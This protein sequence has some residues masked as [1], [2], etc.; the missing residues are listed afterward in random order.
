TKRRRHLL[1]G[2]W[3]RLILVSS[4]VGTWMNLLRRR[5]TT[6]TAKKMIAIPGRQMKRTMKMMAVMMRTKAAAAAPTVVKAYQHLGSVLR[7]GQ[8]TKVQ[9]LYMLGTN[10]SRSL[11]HYLQLPQ[12]TCGQSHSLRVLLAPT[13]MVPPSDVLLK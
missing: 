10:R 5:R 4:S 1:M 6:K 11:S 12:A 9:F 2:L 8:S 13:M 3:E 7:P